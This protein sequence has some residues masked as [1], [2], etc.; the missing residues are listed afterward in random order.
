MKTRLF[1]LAFLVLIVSVSCQRAPHGAVGVLGKHGMVVSAHPEASAIG[2]QILKKGGNAVDAACAVGFALSVC[3]PAAGNIGGGGFMVI[4][5]SRGEV[6]TLNYREKAP[7]ASSRDMYLDDRSN[8]IPGASTNTILATGVPGS[9]AGL[10]EAHERYGK[11]NWNDLVQPAIHLAQKG[12]PLTA[13]QAAYLNSLKKVFIKRNNATPIPFV[14]DGKWQKGDTLRQPDLA[15]TLEL[16]RDY[17]KDGFY[18][19]VT[20]E[21]IV[22]FIQN[23][24]GLLT[25]Q[26][27]SDYQVQWLKPISGTYR[28]YTFYSMPPPSSGG[29]ALYQLLKMAEPYPLKDSGWNQKATVHYLAEVEKRVFADRTRFLGDPDFIDIPVDKL[30]DPEYITRRIK[31]IPLDRA[32]KPDEI[33]AGKFTYTEHTETTHYS[34]TDTWGNA[35]AV[36]TTLNGGYG[37]KMV[38]TGAGFFLNNEMDDFSVKPGVPNM[39]G[40]IGGEANAIAPGKRMLSSMTP[41]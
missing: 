10:A 24:G 38:V 6:N 18:K 25:M 39:Y 26:D 21:K 33:E 13:H 19:G 34:I 1:F 12:F 15:H 40:L 28:N 23:N 3:Y 29:I 9:V 36:T 41:T 27:L 22:S 17:K 32:S 35:V 30:L 8:V 16:I 20:A 5:T 37:N 2:L 31:E 14:K 4:R 7:L 11:L